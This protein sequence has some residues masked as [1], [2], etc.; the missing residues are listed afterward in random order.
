M[1]RSRDVDVHN[2]SYDHF[3]VTEFSHFVY[4]YPM[5]THV[6]NQFVP[7]TKAKI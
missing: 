6:L 1:F 4:Y 3:S 7:C 5:N 2:S